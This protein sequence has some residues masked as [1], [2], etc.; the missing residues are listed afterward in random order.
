MGGVDGWPGIAA[1]LAC[2]VAARQAINNPRYAIRTLD[3]QRRRLAPAV[4][5]ASIM[6][7]ERFYSAAPGVMT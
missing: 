1:R 6:C 7:L 2:G 3:L 5:A 4:T